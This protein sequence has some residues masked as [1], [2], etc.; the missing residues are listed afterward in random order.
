MLGGISRR[1][2]L[3]GAVSAIAGVAAGEAPLRSIRPSPKPGPAVAFSAPAV[4]DLVAQ[5]RLGGNVA[6]VVADARTG[7]VLEARNPGLG[8]PP[9]SVTKMVT[10]LYAMD[11][12]GED[13]RYKTEFVATGPVVDGV[14]Q[15]DLVLAG[16]GD[17][18]LD[19]DA[20]STMVAKL[21]DKGVTG[22]T[23]AFRIYAGALPYIRSIDPRQPDHV[24]YNPTISGINLNF[25]RVHFQWQ[26]ADAGWQVSM[27]A[28]SKTLRPAVTVARMAVVNRDMPTY[29]Y[30]TAQGVDEWTVAAAAL[31]NGGS[32]W[33]P[34]RRPDLYAG[35]VTQVIAR[36]HG[37]RLPA[38]QVAEREVEG[39]Q[40]LVAHD[41]ASL[42]T[43]VRL[44]LKY[45]TNLS[46]EVIGLTATAARGAPADSLEASAKA[47]T[48][49]IR[50]RTGATSAH[51]VDHSGLSDLSRIS[52]GDLVKMLVEVGPGS[53]L[54]GQL[55]EITPLDM[56][57]KE[58]TGAGYRIHAKTGSLNFVSS[59]A[60][61][62]TG[63]GDTALA[64]AVLT[65]DITRRAAIAP[66]DMERPEG[67]RSWAR[68]ARW[69]QHQMIHRW[70]SLYNSA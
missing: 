6:F 44:M 54:H 9:A 55:K 12:L 3:G 8:L 34:V 32:R 18:M 19:T 43:I 57:G 5:A 60:G 33:L 4:A 58:L 30:S 51:F 37:I 62:V 16:S 20:L 53:T 66:D 24:G 31:G 10:A 63:P 17:P 50:A 41:S 21:K 61:F 70:S 47:M 69:L 38:P 40:V 64:F 42:S 36:A 65:G 1:L 67:A 11:A 29:T 68:R 39:G 48:D 56:K 45:S 25:N 49:W 26:R 22:L 15:G 27:D 2:F 46:A 35:E 23:G 52:A 14:I 13:F 7:R 59:L 28:R